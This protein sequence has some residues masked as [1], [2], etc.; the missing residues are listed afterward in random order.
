M[1]ENM[2]KVLEFVRSIIKEH[3]NKE[4]VCIDMT[5]GNGNDTLFLCELSRFV[6]G[7]DVQRQAIENTEKLLRS[8]KLYNYEIIH[9][10]HELVD[11]YVT[12]TVKYVMYNLGY[13]PSFN[14]KITTRAA[15]TITSLKKVLN[16]LEKDGI[17]TMVVYSGHRNGKTEARELLKFVKTLDQKQYDV[18]KYDFINQQNNPPFAI[19]IKRR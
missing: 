2:K 19:I 4:D 6:Y 14:K 7:F 18:V 16:L 15:S 10:S 3:I 9:K 13:M 12:G 8:H 1:G 11:E 17:I 5:L